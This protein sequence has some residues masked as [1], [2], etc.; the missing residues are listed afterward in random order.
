MKRNFSSAVAAL[1]FCTHF[2]AAQQISGS[3]TGVVKDSQQAAVVNAKILLNSNEQGTNR[4]GVTATDGSFVFTQVQPG[5]YALT[6]ESPGFKKFEQ[7]DIKVFANDRVVL[8]DITLTVG[9]LNETVTVEAQTAALE[10]ASAERAG[11]LTARQVTDLAEN[12]RSLFDLTRVIPGVVYTGGLGGIYAN[13][14]RSDQNNFTLDGVTNVDTGSNGG[15]LATTNID[16]I[17]EMKVITNSQPAEFGRASGAQIEVVTKSGTKDIHGTGYFFHRNEDLNANSWRNNVDGR[18]KDPYRYN[19]EGFNVGGPAYIPGKFNRNRD[20]LFFFVGIEWQGQLVPQGLHNVTVPTQAERS[21]DFSQTHDGG[22]F[23]PNITIFDPLNNKAPFPGNIIPKD[24]INADGQKILNFYPLPNAA[25][26]D[27]SYNYQTAFSNQYPRREEIYRGDYNIT[28]KWKAYARFIRNKDETSMQYGQWNASYNIPFGPMSF[29]SPGWSVVTNVTTII[30]PTLTNEFVFGSSRN[31]LHIKPIN[32]A[33]DETKLGLSYKMPF[34]NADTLHLIQN[35]GYGG[36]PNAPTSGFAGTPFL[37]FNHTYDITDSIAKVHDTH[38]IKAGIYL[39]KSLKDQTA[40]TSVNGNISFARD[41][42]NPN[43]ANWAFANALLGN[44]D[45]LQQSNQ[46]L[47]GQYRS[48]NVEWYVEDNWRASRKLTL[49]YGMRF[50]W[51]QPQ[52]DAALQTSSFNPGLYD[53]ANAAVLRTAALNSSGQRVSVNPL[54]GEIGP[55]ALIGSIVNNGKG[56]INGIYANGMGLAGKGYPKG[57]MQDRGIQFAPRLGIAYQLNSKTVIRAGGGVFYDRLQGNPVFDMLPNPPSTIIPQFY[58]GNLGAIPPASAGTF[59][60]AGVV[61]F[62][63]AGH[64]PTTYNWNLTI[65]RQLPFSLIMDVAYVGSVSNHDPYRLNENAIPLGAAWLP[66]NQDPLN[67]N[68]KFDG[69]TS[70]QPN[71]YRPRLGYTN[72]TDYAFGANSN[73][74][75]LQTSAHRRF[76]KSLT[77]GGAYTWSKVMGTADSYS[78]TVNP[79]NSRVADYAPLGYDRTHVASF[80]W[81]Y[82]T[83]EI[84]KSKSAMGKVGGAIVNNWQVSGIASFMTGGPITPSFSISGIGNLNERYTGSPDVGPRLV[85]TSAP[86]YPK[87]IYQWLSPAGLAL[88]PVKGSQGFDSARNSVRNPGDN[89]WDISTFKNFKVKRE[90]TYFQLRVEMFNAF[91]H[92]RFNA[93]NSSAQFNTAGQLVNTPSV[94]G[95]T[96]G[97]FGFGALTGTADPRRIQLAAKFYF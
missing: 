78:S 54:T 9:A 91:N 53:P 94:L 69:T 22:T 37:N 3:I 76:G 67:A 66:Q 89:D 93:F 12:G 26:V 51:V 13:G 86:S 14:S 59:F 87:S 49:E 82:N 60:P 24:R 35:W 77:F 31:D 6:V 68:P 21:G 57:L 4:E 90:G 2:A 34:P 95:G 27:P 74:N 5:T 70:N 48:W 84:L 16:M 28:E 52:Y 58:Y 8:T 46:V 32:D 20:K 72:T 97:R 45:T 39:H 50:Y 17:A 40:F 75:A 38:T 63:E 56:F 65:Q 85:M 25:G 73:Y 11:V 10:T 36:V 42:N 15:A 23:S 96:G 61:G 92:T 18:G 80:N 64:I 44:Y 55:A 79:F 30:N 81:V 41:A 71:F 29:G 83:P 1:L 33:F 7:K 19:T 47:N 88:P 43:D 62:D